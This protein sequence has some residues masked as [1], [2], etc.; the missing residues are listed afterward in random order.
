[1]S[2]SRILMTT[3]TVGG[4][5]NYSLGLCE[6]LAAHGVVVHLSTLGPPA[7][8]SQLQKAQALKNVVLHESDYRLEWMDDPWEDI[9]KAGKWLLHLEDTVGPDLVHLNGYVHASLPWAAPVCVV[10]HSCVA[11]WWQ[12][13]R[14]ESI[15]AEWACYR[16]AVARGLRMAD[17]VI[18]PTAA[19]LQSLQSNY[20]DLPN[21][22]VVPNGVSEK[23][24]RPKNKQP[25]IFSAGRL[26][27]AGKNIQSLVESGAELEWPIV[28]AGEGSLDRRG[29]V[30][31]LGRLPQEK[32]A[33]WMAVA[34]IYCLPARYE[35]FGLSVLE[36]ALSGCA[37]VLGDIPSLNELWKG[38]A[39]FVAPEDLDG[40]RLTLCRL[41]EDQLAREQLA[42]LSLQRAKEFTV[43]RMAK[44]YLGIY[45]RAVGRSRRRTADTQREPLTIAQE[46]PE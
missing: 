17:E 5:W 14:Q 42:R 40:L 45:E 11:S 37:L 39:V 38:A 4:V 29:N 34:S 13:V 36:A 9:A 8:E 6:A 7:A 35:P 33:E 23:A 16:L 18:A 2:V 24:F 44:A 31:L 21:G 3:D 19:M 43:E 20:G 32:V 22:S 10:A 12:A 25:I 27:D 28:I 46:I 26:W 41:I 30:S 1:M 15:P